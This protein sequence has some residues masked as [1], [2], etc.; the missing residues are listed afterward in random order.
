MKTETQLIFVYNADS[1]KLNA[2][3]DMLH[4]VFSPNTYPCSLCAITYGPF[5]MHKEWEKFVGKLPCSVRFL[6]RDEWEAEFER[7]DELPAVFVQRGEVIQILIDSKRM[8]ELTLQGLMSQL[9]LMV[10]DLT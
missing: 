10:P 5:S 1:G 2:Y 7:R 6:H 3:L 4:K 9:E 8:D